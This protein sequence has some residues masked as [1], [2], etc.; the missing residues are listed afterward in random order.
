MSVAREETASAERWRRTLLLNRELEDR[1]RQLGEAEELMRAVID[2]LDARLV[3]LGVDGVIM[4]ANRHWDTLARQFGWSE[5]ESGIGGDFFALLT[6]FGPALD[7]PVAAALTRA[8]N[9]TPG[10][11]AV[12]GPTVIGTRHEHVIFRV[13]P[14]LD[15][16]TARA[17]VAIV[18]ITSADRTRRQLDLI[19]EEATLLAMVA[20]HTD[21]GVVITDP[22]GRIEWVNESFCTGTGYSRAE[23]L[24][25]LRGELMNIPGEPGPEVERFSA[26]VAAGRDAE[27]Q[28][29]SLT[30]DGRLRWLH[31]QV[32]TI[33]RHGRPPQRVG[34][35]LD[36]T[37]LRQAEQQL[38]QANRLESIG[39]LAAGIAHE[40]NTPVQFVADNTQFL[41]DSFG[42]IMRVL[43]GDERVEDLDLDFLAAEIP[44]ALAQT[45]EGLQRI[46]LIVRA[47]KD[48]AHPGTG[49]APAD[50][51]R[52]VDTTVQVCRN[53][54]KYVAEVTLDLD[55]TVGLV[56]C[57]EGELKQALLNIVVNAAQ[58]IGESPRE[59]GALGHIT[60]ST[61][62][63]ADSVTI[64]VR[65]D[66][67]GI[68]PEVQQRIFDPF[69]TTKPV[70]KGTGQGLSM[71]YASIV[72]KHGG[73]LRVDSTPGSGT[74]FTI[75]LPV[76]PDAEA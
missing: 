43:N 76:D 52:A 24:G 60:V 47:M 19:T 54:W 46:A 41:A 73:S 55:P 50:V 4:G 66:G 13:H 39:Q 21:H 14:V 29:P 15:H 51:N 62:R 38:A 22:E 40:I 1:V 31:V 9:G 71:A 53:E 34:I 16:H 49:R 17:V 20:Q 57:Y 27:V 10:D 5:A 69:F 18:D 37:Q 45:Q 26:D 67:P 28:L 72:T 3:I 68:T 33:Q 63:G 58:A 64:E 74:T 59:P 75:E 25:R 32:K 65:D 8:L 23:A 12:K 2:S 42:H 44:D 70:G 7:G 56:P 30:K 6:Q 11:Q 61:E 48:F 35:E 36:V